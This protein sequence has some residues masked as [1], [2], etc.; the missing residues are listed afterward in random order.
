MKKSWREYIDELLL[1][2]LAL[3]GILVSLFDFLGWFENV[4]WLNSQQI[5]T[6]TLLILSGVALFLA[7]ERRLFF[8]ANFS[9]FKEAF[10][11]LTTGQ[12][13]STDEIIQALDGVKVRTFED[14]FDLLAY[15][16]KRVKAANHWIDDTSWGV[17]LGPE[18]QLPQNQRIAKEHRK[19]MA[20][21]A[22]KHPYRELFVFNQSYQLQSML[23]RVSQ[24]ISGY[25]CAYFPDL[26]NIQLLKFMIIDHKEIILLADNFDG[27]MSIQH[28]KIV[29]MFEDYYNQLWAQA[30]VIKDAHGVRQDVLEQITQKYGPGIQDHHV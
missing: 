10:S 16:T 20:I 22:K 25:S 29:K 13:T 18:A 21:F 15:T 19:Q 24:D 28:P 1:G 14:A 8:E 30:T 11:K 6:L 23:S 4:P 5:P 26:T 12:K 7:V 3:A 17:A 2:L 27:N 9:E